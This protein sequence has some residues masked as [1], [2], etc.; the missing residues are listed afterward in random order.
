[1]PD[2]R[3]TIVVAFGG[4][5]ITGPDDTGEIHEQFYHARVAIRGIREL[6]AS[7]AGVAITHGNG[8]QVGTSLHRMELARG[9]VP[10]RPLGVLVADTQGG[11]GYMIA[12]V[13]RNW[14]RQEGLDRPVSAVVTQV[15]VGEDDPA[16]GAPTKPVGSS[17]DAETAEQLRAH[18]WAVSG[19]D[20]K[21]YRRLVPSPMPVRIVEAPAIRHLMAEG[22][23]VI[24]CGGGGIPVIETEHGELD[25]VDAVVDKDLAS[26][27]LAREIGA[28]RLIIL[29]AVNKVV[30]G[31]G[32]PSPK[33]LDRLTVAEAERYLAEGEFPPGSMGPKIQ[34]V[35]DFLK[36]GGKEALITSFAALPRAWK[37]ED[38]TRIFP[39]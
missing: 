30:L 36:H 10:P 2:S 22:Q 25:G 33:P 28:D 13:V 21:G 17:C 23:I 38:G 35:V 34:G 19:D 14:L 15:V 29:T 6:L 12:Q 4:N 18:G 26:A 8:P 24:A 37:G 16:M 9:Q 20:R 31:F 11:I 27:L 39:E 1:M 32:S 3:E 5:A 7:G